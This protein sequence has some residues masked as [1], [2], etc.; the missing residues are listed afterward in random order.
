M[1]TR[2]VLARDLNPGDV[3]AEGGIIRSVHLTDQYLSTGHVIIHA[4]QPASRAKWKQTLRPTD[5]VTIKA[6][7][8]DDPFA[9]LKH[10]KVN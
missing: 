8:D 9:T 10:M 1:Q 5:R 7:D 4:S 2:S 3:L 6:Y